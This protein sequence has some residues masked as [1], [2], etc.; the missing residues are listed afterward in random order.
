MD[1]CV[2]IRGVD[3][4]CPGS[5]RPAFSSP[6]SAS[7]PVPVRPIESTRQ[8]H[9]VNRSPAAEACRTTEGCKEIS[10]QHVPKSSARAHY[11]W[12]DVRRHLQL[13]S[14]RVGSG[15]YLQPYNKCGSLSGCLRKSPS[16]SCVLGSTME[17]QYRSQ[18]GLARGPA[19]RCRQHGEIFIS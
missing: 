13:S 14:N 8:T 15:G 17:V 18:L 10:E 5:S 16:C 7:G 9:P 1:Y 19:K 6:H 3:D 11:I 4:I 2:A 12:V